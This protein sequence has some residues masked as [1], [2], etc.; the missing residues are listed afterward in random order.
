MA[1]RLKLGT[2]A[3]GAEPGTPEVPV[4]ASWIA[5]HRGI[6]ADI[7]TYQLE[8][9]LLPQLSAG[10]MAPCAGGK[11]Y[12]DRIMACL[13]GVDDG[14]AKDEISINPHEIIRDAE[15]IIA[16]KKGSWCALPAPH[17]LGIRDSFYDDEE[18]WNDALAGLYRTLMRSMRDTG[19]SGHVL[20][21]SSLEEPE[22]TSLVQQNVFFFQPE[23][24][25]DDL[26]ALMEHQRLVAVG[27]DSLDIL[28][29]LTGEYDVRKIILIDPDRASISRALSCLDPDQ[30]IAGGYCTGSCEDYWKTIVQSATCLV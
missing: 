28:L 18:E 9:S 25:R 1:K 11:F 14:K 17:L 7:I 8:R 19:I 10:I 24:C 15:R 23:P 16:Q 13:N 26:A 6:P 21:C 20:I 29:D 5:E 27:R 22:V 4:L 12:R 30:I 3:L 2:R